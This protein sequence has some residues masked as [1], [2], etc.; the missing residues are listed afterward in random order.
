MA[1]KGANE[2]PGSQHLASLPHTDLEEHGFYHK[3]S[4]MHGTKHINLKLI[5][6]FSCYNK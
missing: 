1:T 3:D 6:K 5:T 4:E 2:I